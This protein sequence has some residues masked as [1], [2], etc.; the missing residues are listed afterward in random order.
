VV[1]QPVGELKALGEVT[2]AVTSIV[3]LE[4]VLN[5]I[6]TKA[7]QLSKTEAGAIYVFDEAK[8]EFQLRATFGLEEAIVAAIAANG[9]AN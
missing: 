1:G 9:L 5:T 7:T 6:V 8:Q 3:N 2:Q 4:T